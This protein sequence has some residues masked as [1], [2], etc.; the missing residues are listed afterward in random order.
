[1]GNLDR[2]PD[3]LIGLVPA[4]SGVCHRCGAATRAVANGRGRIDIC[5]A[6]GRLDFQTSEGLEFLSL[7]GTPLAPPEKKVHADPWR[8]R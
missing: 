3:A 8:L 2:V 1:M 5:G 4:S 7:R 6:C